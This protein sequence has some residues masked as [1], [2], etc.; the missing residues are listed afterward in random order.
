MAGLRIGAER[1]GPHRGP[2]AG[3]GS[4]PPYGMLRLGLRS[5][6]LG[7]LLARVPTPRR[8]PFALGYVA[9]V[10]ATTTFAMLADPDLV[11]RLQE[12]SSSD[13]DNLLHHPL[14]AL[15]FSGFWV[16]GTVWMPYLW[17]FAFTVA[18]LE[19]R[20]G[21]GRA[22]AVFATGHIA[23]TVLSQGV[24]IAAVVAGRLGPA[25]L[26][27]LDIG[28]S[29]GVL[30]SLAALAGLL[31]PMGRLL[32]LGGAALMLADQYATDQDLVTGIGH[33]AALLAGV[34]LWRWLR[35]VPDRRA[36]PGE[37]AQAPAQ[38]VAHA[39]SGASS[40]SGGAAVLD[41]M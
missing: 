24:V 33:P 19:R 40:A 22:A 39:A 8:N 28:V 16:A 5:T 30:A 35:R 4:G 10:G 1:S 21:A 34:A 18:P 3:T 13:G 23:A 32:A 25:E 38:A 27:R 26:D 17:A 7:W 11:L 36:H 20:V 9:V 2:G 6:L 14:R 41:R 15:L 37:A 31:R 12:A 29:Y